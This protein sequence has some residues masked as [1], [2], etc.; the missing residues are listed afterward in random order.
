MGIAYDPGGMTR[1]VTTKQNHQLSVTEIPGIQ[2][3]RNAFAG[4]Q[5]VHVH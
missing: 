3:I 4:K 1:N 5:V 2:L